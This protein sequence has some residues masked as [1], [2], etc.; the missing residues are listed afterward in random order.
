MMKRIFFGSRNN[1][2]IQRFRKLLEPLDL[3][4]IGPADLGTE[5]TVIEDGETPE[6]NAAKKARTYFSMVG[7][8]TFATDYA[9]YID[10]F[11]PEK[12]PG[13]L[14]GRILGRPG[15]ATDAELLD[16]YSD[17]LRKVGGESEASWVVAVAL[18]VA[19]DRVFTRRLTERTLF[20]SAR[21]AALTP[22]EPLNSL[23]FVPAVGKY[24]SEMTAAERA[25]AR[26][27]IDCGVVEFV[28]EHS[29]EEG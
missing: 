12:Q 11:P 23:Q 6:E 7:L 14:V 17:E 8:P 13:I 27:A 25:A 15:N 4:V 29:T 10:N 24:K 19:P 18:A 28:R 21:S 26:L 3:E 9:L 20:R 2:R 16:Y 5:V 1:A 22:G